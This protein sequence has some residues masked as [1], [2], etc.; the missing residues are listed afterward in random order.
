M[1]CEKLNYRNKLCCVGVII[2]DTEQ[3]GTIDG[4]TIGVLV[5]DYSLLYLQDCLRFYIDLDWL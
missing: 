4:K 3:R 2:I 5:T 1:L